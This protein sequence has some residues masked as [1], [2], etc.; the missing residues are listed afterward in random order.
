MKRSLL[1]DVCPVIRRIQSRITRMRY[2]VR[3]GQRAL[4][5][6]RTTGA[7]A[8]CETWYVTTLFNI[9]SISIIL[10]VGTHSVLEY[11]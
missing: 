8:V 4:Y 2:I 1:N 6:E 7:R 10:E 5:I 9:Y 11:S 3:G